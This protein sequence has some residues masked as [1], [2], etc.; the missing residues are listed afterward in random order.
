MSAALYSP[1]ELKQ[2]QMCEEY[3]KGNRTL[4]DCCRVVGISAGQHYGWLKTSEWY[5][6][7]WEMAERMYKAVMA[8]ILDDRIRNG[9]VDIKT[10][11]T[12]IL[13]PETGQAKKIPVEEVHTR[14]FSDTLLTK[15]LAAKLPEEFGKAKKQ[16]ININ[17]AERL[18]SGRARVAAAEGSAD[19][20][21]E[22]DAESEG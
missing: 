11:Y 15:Y 5:R 17:I 9:A 4:V 2:M 3:S 18:I 10:T 16:E 6:T 12:V 8:E 13:D 19:D 14:R 22:E 1:T 21:N 7:G 20:G